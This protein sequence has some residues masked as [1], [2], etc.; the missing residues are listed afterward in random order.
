MT[1][2]PRLAR[3]T[4]AQLPETV[5]R[6]KYDPSAVRTGIVH[7]GLGAFHRAHQAVYTDAVLPI[8]LRWGILGVSPRRPDTRDAL[9]PQDWLYT[10]VERDASGERLR[11]IGALTGA[12]VARR[13]RV[14]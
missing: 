8:D 1:P 14:N 3:A 4:L 13:I 9:A 5:A 2:L 7:L 12:L 6:P 10:L 11:V